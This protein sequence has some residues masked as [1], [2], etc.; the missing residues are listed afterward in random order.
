MD[1]INRK[2]LSSLQDDGRRTTT[3]LASEVG[4]SLSS[5]HRRV[6]DLEASG[7]IQRYRAE[8]S[9]EALGLTF[10]ALIFVTMGRTDQDTVAEFERRIAELP[11]VVTAQRLFGNPD[12]MLRVLTEDLT[13]YQRL[14]DSELGSLPGVQRLNS[15]MVMK[16]IGVDGT[17]PV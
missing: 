10:E 12:Y 5:C 2:I 6:R 7:A 4:M 8:I 15:T 1:A 16:R 13:S 9:P 14:Y 17:I 3:E 11:A